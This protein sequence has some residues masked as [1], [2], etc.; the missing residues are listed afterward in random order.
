MKT[1]NIQP[2]R[3]DQEVCSSVHYIVNMFCVEF[4]ICFKFTDV[5]DRRRFCR[6]MF[7]ASTCVWSHEDLLEE[8]AMRDQGGVTSVVTSRRERSKDKRVLNEHGYEIRWGL[9]V[10]CCTYSVVKTRSKKPAI[11]R[12]SSFNMFVREG[13]LC[14]RR[15]WKRI[16]LTSRI[17]QVNVQELEGLRSGR[18]TGEIGL[19]EGS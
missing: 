4:K 8:C 2:R 15:V 13:E 7:K 19:G 14:F 9:S 5:C 16:D 17:F 11:A 10:G 3:I 12:K 18:P 6:Q 1:E